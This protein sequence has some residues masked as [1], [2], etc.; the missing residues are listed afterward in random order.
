MLE[1][2]YYINHLGEKI[3][4]G[5]ESGIYLNYNDLR[6]FSFAVTSNSNR[7]KSL[8]RTQIVAKKLPLVIAI[9]SEGADE[10]KNK[11]YETLAKDSVNNKYGRIYIGECYYQ[12]FMTGNKKSDY[13][14]KKGYLKIDLEMSTDRPYWVR[15]I[16]SKDFDPD[17]I[18]TNRVGYAVV[19]YARVSGSPEEIIPGTIFDDETKG[20]SITNTHFTEC[21]C[22]IIVN[23][24]AENPYIMIGANVYN[25]DVDVASGQQLKINTKTKEIKLINNTGAET[26]VFMYRNKE[27]DAFEKI[28]MGYNRV[29]WNGSYTIT[30]TLL[31]ERDEAL[32][33]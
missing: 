25:I 12:C 18:I 32:W 11:L 9:D 24:P 7:I 19:G 21:D 8:S 28:K 1:K 14:I 10:I 17:G 33:I 6:D 4:F 20:A 13:L 3:V 16:V 26:N 15:E 31:E 5:P 2:C 23:G 30:I 29:L 22:E 27:H